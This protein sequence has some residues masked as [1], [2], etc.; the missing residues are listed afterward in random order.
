MFSVPMALVDFIPVVCFFIAGL[1]LLGDLYNKMSKGAFALFAAGV[2]DIFMAGSLKAIHKLLYAL[3]I[4][5]FEVLSKMF[6]PVQAIG[7]ML[8]GIGMVCML[9]VKQG[10]GRI[11]SA[12]V[13]AVFSGT[14]IFVLF[15]VLGLGALDFSLCSLSAKLKKKPVMILFILSF[16]FC[17]AMGYLSSKDFSQ[18]YMNWVGEAINALGQGMLLLGTV[19]LHKNGLRELTLEKDA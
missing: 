5:D 11:Y 3:N 6:F 13:P 4:C 17:L 7:F 15:M 9:L 14:M 18:A 8:T 1:I 16:I 19:I 12:G 10:K 2:I